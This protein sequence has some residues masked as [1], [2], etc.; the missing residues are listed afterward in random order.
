M[1]LQLSPL[2]DEVKLMQ[3]VLILEKEQNEFQR[4]EKML[5]L[6]F[7][8]ISKTCGRKTWFNLTLYYL[9]NKQQ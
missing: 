6:N 7:R 2:E 5:F 4:K 9:T 8:I 3:D 1:I